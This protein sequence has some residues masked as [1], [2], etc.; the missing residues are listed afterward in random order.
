LMP[1]F[2]QEQFLPC[3]AECELPLPLA[4]PCLATRAVSGVHHRRLGKE[5]DTSHN[6]PLSIFRNYRWMERN[7]L[8]SIPSWVWGSGNSPFEINRPSDLVSLG[9]GWHNIIGLLSEKSGPNCHDLA[10]KGLNTGW[11]DSGTNELLTLQISENTQEY[12]QFDEWG[13]LL[14]VG[15]YCVGVCQCVYGLMG[16]SYNPDVSTWPQH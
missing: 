16:R 4:S 5:V 2:Y 6:Q 8:S 13:T 15:G 12:D 14:P 3:V 11:D 1:I 10:L 7:S 9:L